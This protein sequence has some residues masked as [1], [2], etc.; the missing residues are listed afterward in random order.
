MNDPDLNELYIV[1]DTFYRLAKVVVYT[2]GKTPKE[3][4][5]EILDLLKRIPPVLEDE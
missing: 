1:D 5:K 3:T 2:E 4:C